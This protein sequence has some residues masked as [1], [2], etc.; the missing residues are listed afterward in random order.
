MVLHGRGE[1]GSRSHEGDEGA[2]REEHEGAT[3]RGVSWFSRFRRRR[4][5]LLRDFV[6]Q[7]P[8]P[9]DFEP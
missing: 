1:S 6:V 8:W 5:A 9:Q 4:F 2:K 3:R 7:T